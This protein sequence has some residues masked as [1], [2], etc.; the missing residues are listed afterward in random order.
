M[1]TDARQV[2]DRKGVRGG[3]IS[4]VPQLT[5]RSGNLNWVLCDILAIRELITDYIGNLPFVLL[6]K[7]DHSVHFLGT[8][9]DRFPA[10]LPAA[11]GLVNV[12]R[13]VIEVFV[14]FKLGSTGHYRHSYR[15][16]SLFQ[17]SQQN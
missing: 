10:S 14:F 6:T 7:L 3:I 8:V 11:S 15:S 12:T 4:Q 9:I 5:C 1:G 13:V 17:A 2:W 16:S